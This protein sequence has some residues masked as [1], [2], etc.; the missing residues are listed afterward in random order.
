MTGLDYAIV[1][2]FLALTAAGGVWVAR[3][4]KD[5]D[6]FFVAGRELTPFILAA[7]ITATNLSMFHIVGMGGNTYKHGVSMIWQN[8]TGN[9]ALVLS[10]CLVLP[11]M[12]RLRI[13]SVPEFLEMR[14]GR[15]LR[16]I[17]GAFWALRLCVYLGLLLYIAATAAGVITGW[18]N[19]GAWLAIFSAVAVIYSTVG[20]AWA[21]AIMD[22]VQFLVMLA[23]LLI[24]FP[25]AMRLGGGL[26]GMIE[27]FRHSETMSRHVEL[28]PQ[29]GA[30]NWVFISSI[31]LLGH[32]VG[33][34]RPG[35]PP[36]RLRRTQP[37]HRRQGNGPFRA[38]HDAAD[39]FMDPPRSRRRPR[40]ADAV[41]E[42]GRGDPLAALVAAPGDRARAARVRP[43]RAGRGAGLDHHRGRELRRHAVHSDVYRTLTKVEP[44]QRQLLFV[45]RASS[46]SC[47]GLMLAVAW[48][49]QYDTSG[50]S[51]ST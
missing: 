48:L 16:T 38:D 39:V 22:S 43:L 12:R 4:I 24:V 13:R 17:V 27:F 26:P 32:Q 36:A 49:L 15:S 21:V 20:G 11:I 10:G 34:D 29:T 30:F 8:W 51:T 37:A 50:R 35:D 7:T 44:T 45:V 14:Y 9:I 6:D 31:M 33:D 3:L 40:G 25:I 1:I 41:P 19:Y 2:V 5:S 42:P 28:V 23:G 47:G 46:L 18:R